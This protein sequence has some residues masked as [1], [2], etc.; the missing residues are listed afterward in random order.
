MFVLTRDKEQKGEKN[1][2][3]IFVILNPV[4]KQ[5]KTTR[6]KRISKTIYKLTF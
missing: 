1:E 6:A 2:E 4:N 3:L 5:E